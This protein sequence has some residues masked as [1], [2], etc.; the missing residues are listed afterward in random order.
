MANNAWHYEDHRCSVC[1]L[2]LRTAE[3]GW[4]LEVKGQTL[5][6]QAPAFSTDEA[7]VELEQNER[8]LDDVVLLCDPDDEMGQLIP[9]FK[10]ENLSD[11]ELLLVPRTRFPSSSTPRI[12]T[13]SSAIE[14][15]EALHRGGPLFYLVEPEG[16]KR[17]VNIHHWDFPTFDGRAYIPIHSN[18]LT[19]AKKVL[20]S[21]RP[22]FLKNMRSLFLALRWRHAIARISGGER[23]TSNF[24]LQPAYWYAP[25]W[26]FWEANDCN[27]NLDRSQLWPGPT[28]DAEF[29]MLY[30]S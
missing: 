3:Q 7:M 17:D 23:E 18:C 29:N 9:S 27:E 2:P 21:S 8:W 12:T 22:K 5:S 14:E 28:T 11:Y 24:M 25:N 13:K 20:A 15:H 6:F 1:G 4:L 10:Y 30:V 19:I 16:G 26:I